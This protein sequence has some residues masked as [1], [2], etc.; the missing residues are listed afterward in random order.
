[1]VK[2]EV[3][4]D[5]EIEVLRRNV[6]RLLEEAERVDAEEDERY[7]PDRRGDELPEALRDREQ[8]LAVIRKAKQALEDEARE[9]E[10]ARRAELERQGK[11]PRPPRDGRDP[12][13]PKPS[14]QRNFTDP[15]SRIMKTVGRVV[16]S[17]LQR[18]GG[19]RLQGAGDRCRRREQP[20]AGRR[21]ARPGARP[22]R[23]EPGGGRRGAPRR[24]DVDRRRRLLLRTTTSRRRART[25]STRTSRPAGSSTA[26]HQP[27]AP[28]GP[29][30]KDAT[31]KQRMARKL[32]TKRGRNV[33]ARRKTI[34]EP[35]FGQMTTTQDARRLRLRGH[36]A[37][38]AQWRFNCAI[39]NLLKLHRNGGLA[40]IQP[41][42]IAQDPPPRL[43]GTGASTPRSFRSAADAFRRSF[44]HHLCPPTPISASVLLTDPCS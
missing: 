29:I 31:P 26:S 18:A 35:V 40:R 14:A 43:P 5:A 25:A 16:P 7:G 20:G 3:E 1:M 15:E 13:K 34:V 22:A 33:Y 4:L 6:R 44:R 21:T 2:K 23:R 41:H 30:A 10:T 38:R 42:N 32:K 17:V 37:A 19:R 11:K 9:R 24:G 36:D 39:H 27:P 8:R 28:R 12:Y